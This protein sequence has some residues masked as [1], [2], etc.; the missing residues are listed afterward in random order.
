MTEPMTD[1]SGSGLRR[2]RGAFADSA[3]WERFEFRPN[4]VVITTP[5]K[6]GTTWMQTIVGMLIFGRVDLGEPLS[7]LSPWLDMLMHTDDQVFGVLERQRHRRFFKTHTPIDGIPRV[8]GVSYIAVVRHPLDVA[9]SDLDHASNMHT[10]RAVE[11][12]AAASGAPLPD[13]PRPERPKEPGDYLRWFIDNDEQPCGSGPYGLAD[14]SQQALTYWDAREGPGVHLFHYAEMWSDLDR[15]MR[16]VADALGV[17]ADPEVWDE[18][19]DAA[20]LDSMRS[21]ASDTVPNVHQGIWVD[22]AKFFRAGG[23]RDWASLL[24]ADDVTHFEARAQ[25]LLGPATE[26]ALGREPSP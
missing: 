25:A 1:P 17:E 26:W 6:S 21:R 19:V 10:E 16:R 11:L 9:L 5:S 2:Y 15:Q 22:P 8:D 23:T 14:F 20:T 4:D 18:L 12:L 3:R 24:S 13:E 7:V